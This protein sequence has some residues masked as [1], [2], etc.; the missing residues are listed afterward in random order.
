[1]AEEV[2]RSEAEIEGLR[3]S[4]S[5]LT[6]R[7][8]PL[9]ALQQKKADLESDINKFESLIEK[10][11]E[12]KEA[13]ERKSSEK[14]DDL[15]RAAEDL[16]R[17]EEENKDL[18][19]VVSNQSIN[20]EDVTRMDQ[21]RSKLKDILHSL[22]SQKDSLLDA[23]L[24]DEAKFE[25]RVRRSRARPGST[26]PQRTGCSSSR[27]PRSTPRAWTLRS[28]SSPTPRTASESL[29]A[30]AS[31]CKTKL[32]P[33]LGALRESSARK[34]R[35]AG[36]EMAEAQEKA[37]TD[38]ATKIAEIDRI[39]GGGGELKKKI[40]KKKITRVLVSWTGLVCRPPRNPSAGRPRRGSWSSLYPRGCSRLP[41]HTP[42]R[43]RPRS[44][45][46]PGTDT[47]PPPGS[48]PPT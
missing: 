16:R 26:T 42:S 31:T 10:L 37:D 48:S 11:R 19:E 5:G 47:P 45:R 21:Q 18:E 46:F 33:A 22:T 39:R 25:K 3:S 28:A 27:P 13:V 29:E 43:P 2:E 32:K 34:T 9:E 8:T 44:Q 20:K 15:Q 36:E 1:M 35:Q 23:A 14:H 12:H 4:I 41:C 24:E 17:V 30:F 7:P 40:P 38:L 6:Q